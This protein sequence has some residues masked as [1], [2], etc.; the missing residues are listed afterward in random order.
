MSRA[1]KMPR[2]RGP[3]LDRALAGVAMAPAGSLPSQ[4]GG[5]GWRSAAVVCPWTAGWAWTG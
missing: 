4:M 5:A 1:M 2:R 3:A